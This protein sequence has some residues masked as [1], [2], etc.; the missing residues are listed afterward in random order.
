MLPFEDET[1]L[2]LLFHLNS[3]P[4]GNIDAYQRVT[5]EVE[6]KQVASSAPPL[7]LP[8]PS[9]S[10]ITRLAARRW[11]CRAY[12]PKALPLSTLS[13]LLWGSYGAIR[14]DSILLDGPLALLRPVPSAGGL[15]PLELYV[16]TQRVQGLA[17]GLHHYNVRHHTLEPLSNGPIF[18]TLQPHLFMYPAIEHANAI[19]FLAAVFKRTQKKYGARG[20][21]YILLEAGHVAQ[22][23]CLLAVE[24]SLGSLCMGGYSDG[25]LNR[26]LGLSPLH[27]GVVYSVAVGWPSSNEP[28]S[29][30]L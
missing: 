3:E 27:E 14:T 12:E 18:K 8:T 2:S 4:W 19:V 24:Q 29:K 6:Y 9:E 28:R 16:A 22:N 23:L 1:S 15:F 21:R 17:D 25:E 20:Y 10:G 13:A 5:Y 30:D 26:V 11:S 7:A